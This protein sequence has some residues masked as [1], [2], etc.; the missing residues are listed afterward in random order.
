MRS[1]SSVGLPARAVSTTLLLVLA[2]PLAAQEPY[3][4][5]PR[6][7]VDALDAP[8][9]PAVS[10]S[11]DRTLMVLA[12]RAGMPTIAE[13]SEPMLRLAGARIN[14]RTNGPH[15]A[16]RFTAL[17]VKRIA[18]GQERAIQ[19]PAGAQLGMPFFSPTGRHIAFTVTHAVG[20]DL[21]TA[22]VETGAASR[23]AGPLNA[24]IGAPGDWLPDGATLLC[25]FVPQ[26]RG[27]P[28]AEA[29][30]PA[31]PNV[32]VAEGRE[33]PTRTYEDMLE[34]PHDERLFDY[35]A[36]SR[37]GLVDV[38]AGTTTLLGEPGVYVAAD[39][40]PD[41]RYLLVQRIHRPWSYVVPSG[42]FPRL[43]EVWDRTG[44]SV[45][46]VADLPLGDRIPMRGTRDGPRGV[47]W[48]PTPPTRPA[49]L[50]WVEAL[51]GGDL[52]RAVPQR[53]R[54]MTLEV[55]AG[56]PAEVHRTE[57]RAGGVRWG[58]GER[59]GIAV[60]NEF[61]RTARRART[62]LIN[63]DQA[64][65]APRLMFDVATEDRYADPGQPM[66]RATP[67]GAVLQQSPDGRYL[68]LSGAGA[69]PEG[70][71]PFFDRLDLRTMRAERLFRSADPYYESVVAALDPAGTRILTSRESVSEP[72]NY[73]VRETRGGAPA[74]RALTAFADPAPQVTGMRKQLVRYRRADGVQLSGTLYLPRDYQQGTRL[75]LVLWVYPS[76]FASADAAGQIRTSPNRFNRVAGASHLFLVTQGYAVLDNPSLPVVGGDTANNSYVRQVVAGAQ[77]AIDHVVGMGVA[78]R[79]RVGV[80]GHS[81]G[82]FTTANLLAHS[83][84]FRT[85]IARSG[86]YNRTLTPFGFQSEQRTF[87]E[88]RDVYSGMSP[89]NYAHQVNEPILLIH[90]EADDNS[91]TFPIQSDRFYAALR[92][93]GA[94]VTL[95]T[96]PSEAHGYAGRESVLDCVARMIEWF[97]RYV[98]PETGR[99]ASRAAS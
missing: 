61:D 96:Y 50:A 80:G 53:D 73:F 40:S 47:H 41:G 19:T 82:A 87:W 44:R 11:P 31:G 36:T 84:L 89:F 99:A 38:T 77:A 91:G 16:G 49:T 52:R 79:A 5:P 60:I 34:N 93:L 42:L 86:A 76:E 37:L 75:P 57:F 51:D 54:L 27:E 68:Y 58:A 29:A 66:M 55:A 18:D 46:Q 72:P 95:V 9:L 10:L 64:G 81:Y 83:D 88:A 92:G 7:V 69:S 78:D 74:P 71:R 21:W 98:K 63:P 32:H 70:D 15:R 12:E 14:P 2:L 30:V 22:N 56:A 28:P 94:Q 90:G 1:I 43:I 6:V 65:V 4:T 45:R 85:G 67:G 17:R 33:A 48:R 39:A 23:L 62:W 3:R 26:D 25:R 13:L 8:Q 20:V 97:D 35:Y 59:D 24:A